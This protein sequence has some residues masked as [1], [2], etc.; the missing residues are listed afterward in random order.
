[1]FGALWDRAVTL[2]QTYPELFAGTVGTVVPIAMTEVL[3]AVY[4]PADW[5]L[6]DQWKAIV[7]ID[8]FVSYAITHTLWHF[9]DNDHDMHGLI[10][11]GSICF[12]AATLAVHVFGVR[13]VIHKWPWIAE[14]K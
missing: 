1:M 7:P 8:F 5:T 4:F 6:K 10:V 12:A 3:R 11:V 14:D 9:L 2:F 13:F